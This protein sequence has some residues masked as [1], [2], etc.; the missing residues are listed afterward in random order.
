MH[1]PAVS[2]VGWA[3]WG[4]AR[5]SPG[6]A[7]FT[8]SH[9]DEQSWTHLMDLSLCVAPSGSDAGGAAW[10]QKWLEPGNAPKPPL[11]PLLISETRWKRLQAPGP[12]RIRCFTRVGDGFVAGERIRA[13]CS[14]CF[15]PLFL[16][17]VMSGFTCSRAAPGTGTCG[18][19]GS[20][21][22]AGC[23]Q[24]LGPGAPARQLPEPDGLS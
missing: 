7:T 16:C 19:V 8:F 4:A 18:P 15:L 23:G 11:C 21:P 17:F 3:V 14:V 22:A 24:P 2:R 1:G 12:G 5:L 9:R 6:T 20:I 13:V 10:E